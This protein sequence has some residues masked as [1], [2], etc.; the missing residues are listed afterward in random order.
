MRISELGW[1]VE[2]E[3]N[4]HKE[5]RILWDFIVELLWMK[6][7]SAFFWLF[8]RWNSLEN[9]LSLAGDG[10]FWEWGKRLKF[11]LKRFLEI[12]LKKIDLNCKIPTFHMKFRKISWILGSPQKFPEWKSFGLEVDPVQDTSTQPKHFWRQ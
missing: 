8:W 12:V 3:W 2:D 9:F 1:K 4:V 7:C 6:F 5:K 11:K 10:N